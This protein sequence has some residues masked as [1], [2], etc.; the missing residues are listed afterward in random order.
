MDSSQTWKFNQ[1]RC[2]AR[3]IGLT[4]LLLTSNTFVSADETCQSPYLPKIT[5]QE[6]YVYVWT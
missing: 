5:G 6:D 4:L 3:V 2:V 1:M